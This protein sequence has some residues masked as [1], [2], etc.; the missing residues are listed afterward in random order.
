MLYEV[1]TPFT[2]TISEGASGS[3]DVFT[4]S[5]TTDETTTSTHTLRII[6]P[7]GFAFGTGASVMATIAGDLQSYTQ[8][9]LTQNGKW[10]VFSFNIV[11][12]VSIETFILS[13]VTLTPY[14][15]ITSYNVCYTKLLRI[16]M[17]PA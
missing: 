7:K 14:S 15:R 17:L 3:E 11:N 13:N 16:C 1:I 6:A 4:D 9:S 5:I 12:S 10:L 2:I 8:V